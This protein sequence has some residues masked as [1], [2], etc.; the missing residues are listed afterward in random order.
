MEELKS[1]VALVSG[2]ASGIGR[3][4]AEAIVAEGGRVMIGDV[5]DDAGRAVADSLGGA[6][7]YV[8]LDIRSENDWTDAAAATV[9]AFGKLN[10]L[11]NNAGIIAGGPLG[12]YPLEDWRRIIETNLTGVFL[13]MSTCVTALKA[14]APSS[15]IN[16][17]SIAGLQGAA[18]FHAYCA[19]KWGIRGVTKSAALELAPLGIRVNSVHP[20]TIRTPMTAGVPDS[21]AANSPLGRFGEVEEVA[22]LVT[23][24]ASDRSSFSTGS[25][26]KVDGGESAGATRSIPAD[27]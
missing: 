3:A 15:I 13:G 9:E 21:M 23:Y 5:A 1:K 27:V 16:M 11:V 14:S 24:L 22:N 25:E 4:C 17:S 10:V 2:G 26:F 19:S 12:E 6:A 8:H 18:G 7:A 20:G